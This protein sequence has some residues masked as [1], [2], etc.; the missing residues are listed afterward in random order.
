MRSVRKTTIEK[1]GPEGVGRFAFLYI[2]NQTHEVVA[3]K[4]AVRQ[5]PLDEETIPRWR[6]R[7]SV[8]RNHSTAAERN[9]TQHERR[10][11]VLSLEIPVAKYTDSL[12]LPTASVGLEKP[13]DNP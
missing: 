4:A 11:R 5:L 2:F 8:Y 13:H 6:R 12:L 7:H 3:T 9:L 1:K 10:P